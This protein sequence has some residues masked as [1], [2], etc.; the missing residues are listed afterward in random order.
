[1]TQLFR[2]MYPD[3]QITKQYKCAK[4]KSF[5]I[6]NRALTQ[7]FHIDLVSK[8]K[9]NPHLFMNRDEMSNRYREPSKEAPY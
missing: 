7:S 5:Y 8:M 4:T 2:N 9:A 1:M 6:L 3:S